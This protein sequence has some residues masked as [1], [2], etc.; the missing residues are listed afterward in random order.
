MPEFL[1]L[2]SEAIYQGYFNATYCLKPLPTHDGIQVR[3]NRSNFKHCTYESSKRD[4][5]KDVFSPQRAERLG[6]IKAA[7]ANPDLTLYA[8][9][10]KERQCYD[11]KS[12]VTMMVD[13]FIVVIRLKSSTEA[14]FVTSYVADSPKTKSKILS[15]PIWKNPYSE[16]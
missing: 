4:G 7:L 9:W 8:G 6:W 1:K 16:A 3:F 13:D 14:D 10:I 5:K 15:S 11:H 12:R 2:A